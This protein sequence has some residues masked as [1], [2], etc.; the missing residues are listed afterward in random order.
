MPTDLL[1][2]LPFFI[3]VILRFV[4]PA[5]PYNMDPCGKGT[6][7]PHLILYSVFG[8]A[9]VILGI[10]GATWGFG[11]GANWPAAVLLFAALYSFLFVGF[12]V[13]FFEAYMHSNYPPTPQVG[14]SD[15][16]LTRYAMVLSLGFSSVILLV[17]GSGWMALEVAR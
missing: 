2:A 1:I 7:F 9:Q 4:M 5:G 10:F 11:H 14:K 6:F 12:L 15:Y 3:W 17:V 8:Y 16:T 13:Y